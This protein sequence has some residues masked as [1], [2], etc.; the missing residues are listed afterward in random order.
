M[1]HFH[2]LVQPSSHFKKKIQNANFSDPNISCGDFQ[3]VTG[4]RRPKMVIRI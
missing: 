3:K 2:I 4:I 1:E